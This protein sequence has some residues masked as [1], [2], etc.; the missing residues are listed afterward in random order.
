MNPHADPETRP[1]AAEPLLARLPADRPWLLAVPVEDDALAPSLPAGSVA[2][3]DATDRRLVDGEIYAVRRAEAAEL[4]LWCEGFARLGRSVGG[5]SVGTLA[6]LG[7]PPR[8]RGPVEPEELVVLGRVV[9]ALG[10]AEPAADLVLTLEQERAALAERLALARLELD[11]VEREWHDRPNPLAGLEG[12]PPG[13]LRARLEARRADPSVALRLDLQ[14]RIDALEARIGRLETLIAEAP[15]ISL[16]GVRTKLQ[17]VWSLNHAPLPAV[18]GDLERAAIAS[19]LR[20]LDAL[21]ASEPA[22]RPA[23]PQAPPRSA[24][25]RLVPSPRRRR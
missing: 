1:A 18:E 14:L 10:P 21:L 13:E 4:W 16:E 2:V 24:V 9:G 5:R 23:A 6:S 17:L 19:A 12:L 7:E 20:A 22:A 3:V 15:A 25:L 8:W 11:E